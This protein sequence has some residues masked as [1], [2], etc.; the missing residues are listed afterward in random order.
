MTTTSHSYITMM[1][2]NTIAEPKQLA[3][4]NAYVNIRS[5]K[6]S[7]ELRFRCIVIIKYC[8]HP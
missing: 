5:G 2:T 4:D 8:A 6:E 3:V 7:N 1:K